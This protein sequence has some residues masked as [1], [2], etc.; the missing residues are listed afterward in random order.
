MRKKLLLF[1][2]V[3][4]SAVP[5]ICGQY[6]VVMSD[7]LVNG[8]PDPSNSWMTIA[9][10]TYNQGDPVILDFNAMP[11][12]NY[13]VDDIWVRELSSGNP[14]EVCVDMNGE[15][16]FE[17]PADDVKISVNYV[18]VSPGTQVIV[19]ADPSIVNGTVSPVPQQPFAGDLVNL[20]VTA[21]TGYSLARVTADLFSG[22]FTGNI[23]V[24]VIHDSDGNCMFRV[25]YH[26]VTVTATFTTVSHNIFI[27]PS[28]A[29][30]NI[31][32]VTIAGVSTNGMAQPYSANVGDM[33]VLQDTP[34]P[35]Y[36]LYKY[37]LVDINTGN[38]ITT[39]TGDS[40][41][42]PNEDVMV[43]AEFVP[44]SFTV[45]VLQQP[46]GITE[47]INTSDP[48][49]VPGSVITAYY[50]DQI[51]LIATCDPGYEVD[52][53]DV[54]DVSNNVTNQF[55]PNNP[56]TMPYG[57]VEVTPH[58][59]PIDYTLDVVQYSLYGQGAGTVYVQSINGTAP[60]TAPPYRVHVGDSIKLGNSAD[61][62]NA[63]SFYTLFF[64]DYNLYGSLSLNPPI[65]TFVMPPCDL[66]VSGEFHEL[67][68]PS[69]QQPAPIILRSCRHGRTAS[70]VISALRGQTVI[71]TVTP[72][73]G[74]QV[75]KDNITV[76]LVS[77]DG[78]ETGMMLR[79]V[80]TGDCFELDGPDDYMTEATEYSF[81]VDYPEEGSFSVV[82]TAEF[83]ESGHVYEP[84]DVNHDGI[85]GIADV[86]DLIDYILD[87]SRE[88]CLTC[89]DVDQDG[90]I[91]IA[92]V[93]DLIDLILKK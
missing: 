25:P 3:L 16:M 40:F 85:V 35:G 19:D 27:D 28:I 39:I 60:Q 5:P 78:G 83:E 57:P 59:K 26:T 20:Q 62:N 74:Y 63:F 65:D 46:Y 13:V 76:Q 31:D 30:G 55:G 68:L 67:V 72:D 82:V 29:F 90:L 54:Y 89:G 88:I 47:A 18:S 10:Q 36:E 50:N 77:G 73:E 34:G 52:F 75:K 81:V 38:Y 44:R 33:I 53:F 4:M 48:A 71:I 80:M 6:N 1:F 61:P 51:E 15:Y 92:D 91:G 64:T 23:Y 43:S 93:T 37:F 2:I 9:Q 69:P 45:T 24:R 42:M 7:I 86:T 79:E 17:M 49:S 14:V 41:V 8:T 70:P 21:D 32:V 22:F 87:H 66:I 56:F 11:Q 58:Y 12:G 84:G